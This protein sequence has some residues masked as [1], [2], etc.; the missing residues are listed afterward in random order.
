MITES[1]KCMQHFAALRKP[2]ASTCRVG[3][4]WTRLSTADAIIVHE[5]C[6]KCGQFFTECHA[7]PVMYKSPHYTSLSVML[8]LAQ[9]L[10]KISLSRTITEPTLG[11]CE[12]QQAFIMVVHFQETFV[13]V[14]EQ[15]LAS[16]TGGT[17]GNCWEVYFQE[18][19]C[20]RQC[21][22]L[23]YHPGRVQ[24]PQWTLSIPMVC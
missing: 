19:H 4:G 9:L 22:N 5:F 24:P 13:F 11:P 12:H 2:T 3:G 8:F 23:L 16:Q 6:D 7:R 1:Q 20:M 10:D 18:E 17:I 15:T 21:N 14:W